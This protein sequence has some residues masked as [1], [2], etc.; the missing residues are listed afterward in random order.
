[1]KKPITY[2]IVDEELFPTGTIYAYFNLDDV[3]LDFW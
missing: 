3:I 2:K 1:M